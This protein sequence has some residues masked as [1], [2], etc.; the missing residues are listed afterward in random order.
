MTGNS[1]AWTL[2]GL[3]SPLGRNTFRGNL[4]DDWICQSAHYEIVCL[5]WSEKDLPGMDYEVKLFDCEQWLMKTQKWPDTYILDTRMSFR[6]S[7][8]LATVK[9]HMR[10]YTLE[11]GHDG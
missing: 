9:R 2:S 4:K 1:L 8:S 7:T 6:V 11:S 5:A 10:L 3:S